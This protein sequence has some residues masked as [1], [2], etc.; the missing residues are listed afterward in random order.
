MVKPYTTINENNSVC[1][2]IKWKIVTVTHTWL[3]RIVKPCATMR[4]KP[5]LGRYRTLSAT[6]NPTGKKR[7]EAGM[8]GSINSPSPCVKNRRRGYGDEE[9]EQA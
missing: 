6:T 7:L 1:L 8:K 4:Q 5:M 9:D 3:T 2:V